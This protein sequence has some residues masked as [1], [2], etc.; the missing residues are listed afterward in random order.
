VTYT[1]CLVLR[2]G[3][4]FEH[5]Q[6]ALRAAQSTGDLKEQL[7]AIARQ[8]GY[9]GYLTYDAVVWVCVRHSRTIDMM[10]VFLSGQ[11]YQVYHP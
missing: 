5:L 9:F 3:K 2:L 8:L 1:P 11:R 4:P 6:S 7:M 10:N